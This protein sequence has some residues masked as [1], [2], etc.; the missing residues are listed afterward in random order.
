MRDL[1]NEGGRKEPTERLSTSVRLTIATKRAADWIGR[2][3]GCSQ[4]A[5]YSHAV[6]ELA[7]KTKWKDAT[8]DDVYHPSEGVFWCRLFLLGLTQEDDEARRVEFVSAHRPFFF[9]KHGREWRPDE[10]KI[11][12]LWSLVDYLADHWERRRSVDAWA[13]GEK[14]QDMLKEAKI[15][16]P[17]W[18]AT[19]GPWLGFA[20]GLTV[21]GLIAAVLG[22]V[23]KR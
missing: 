17:A 8:F 13:T 6:A 3:R 4:N 21:A 11:P 12:V 22:G 5:A 19:Y 14:M 23:L 16:P 2:V 15:T 20:G 10:Q 7:D 9:V 1:G 18:A